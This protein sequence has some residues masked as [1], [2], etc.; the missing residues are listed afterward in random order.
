MFEPHVILGIIDSAIERNKVFGDLLTPENK[1]FLVNNSLIRPAETGEVLCHQNQ[2]DNTLY[3]IIDGEVE[4]SKVTDGRFTLLG[5]LGAGELI[6]E[7]SVLY[8]MPRIATVT[9]T[10]PS[11]VL[12]IPSEV[13]TSMLRENPDVQNAVLRRCKQRV[14]ETSIR[15]VPIFNELDGQSFSE[16]CQL[17]SL[18]KA[19]QGV[20]VAHEGQIERSMYVICSGTARVYITVNGKEVNIALLHPGD[21]FGEYSLFTGEARSASVSALTDLQLVEL[22]GESFHSFIDYNEDAEYKISLESFQRQDQLELMRDS[23]I[24]RQAAE[25]RLS[26]VQNMLSTTI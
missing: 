2:A 7:I 22:K 26:Q 1:T 19:D 12:E 25:R 6:G 18:A 3:L 13:F 21:Y 15:C 5:I 16:L 8:M 20:V 23:L 14:I 9:V 11:I 17:S 4:V 24:A 10:Q